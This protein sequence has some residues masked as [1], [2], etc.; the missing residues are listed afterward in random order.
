MPVE[1]RTI[2]ILSIFIEPK[3]IIMSKKI[4]I[5]SI[6]G[7]GIRGIIPGVIL[8]YIENQLQQLDH[9][10]LHIGDYFDFVAGTSTGGILT[11]AYL[12]PNE[13]QTAKYGAEEAV[14]LY[15]KKGGQIFKLSLWDKVTNPWSLLS[16]KFGVHALEEN[17]RELFGE[18]I[19]SE[20]IKPC[21]VPSYNI[22]SRCAKLFTSVDARHNQLEDFKVIDVA[23]S[24]SAAPTYFQPA[25]IQ[26]LSGQTLNLVDGGVYANNPALCAYAEARKIRFSEI[27]KD[28][29]KPDLPS[30]KDMLIISIGTGT[31][32]KSYHFETLKDAGEIKWIEPIIDILMSGNSE[33]VDYQLRQIYNT[34]TIHD[35]QDYYRLE[36]SL[37]EALPEMDNAEADNIENLRQAGLLFVEK[38]QEM[39]DEIIQKILSNK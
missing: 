26:S 24:T 14:N 12:I 19:L 25:R 13:N 6:D 17:F 1:K 23:R 10:S 37:H 32:K 4:R 7:G 18:V 29:E 2:K 21:L 8:T 34:L 16:E 33:T 20:L 3:K 31:V 9:S 15:T 22:T 35:R 27:L 11:C 36:P 38:N 30:A 39:L 28:P 5:L